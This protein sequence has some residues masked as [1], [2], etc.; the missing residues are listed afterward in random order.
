[1]ASKVAS[2]RERTTRTDGLAMARIRSRP[3]AVFVQTAQ[4]PVRQCALLNA[5][6]SVCL[7]ACEYF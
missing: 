5:S 7:T 4:C 6:S 2:V 1:V 3:V